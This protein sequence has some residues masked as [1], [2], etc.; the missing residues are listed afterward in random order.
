M[1]VVAVVTH[2]L[3]HFLLDLYCFLVNAVVFALFR[4]KALGYF[5]D[6]VQLCSYFETTSHK[7]IQIVFFPSKNALKK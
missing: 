6:F 7:T 4:K 2:L 1:K 3:T 5:T